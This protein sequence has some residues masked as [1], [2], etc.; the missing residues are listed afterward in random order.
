MLHRSALV[1]RLTSA[2]ASL[3]VVTA[4]AGYGKSTLARQWV[5]ADPRPVAWMTLHGD[6]DDPVILLRHVARAVSQIERMA[7][8]EAALG[9]S[10]PQIERAV[11]PA[12]EAALQEYGNPML[13]VF[14]DLHRVTNP[15]SFELMERII[16]ASPGGSTV[17]LLSRNAPPVHLARRS[18][19]G[20]VFELGQDD[21]RFTECE[22]RIVLGESLPDIDETDVQA[23]IEKTNCWPAGI[24]LAVMALKQSSNPALTLRTLWHTDKHLADFFRDELLA[25]LPVHTRDFLLDVCVL[26]L[27]AAPLCDA[28]TDR[29][30]SAEMLADLESSDN[31]FVARLGSD[32]TWFRIHPAF[33]EL[34]LAERRRA[35]ADRESVLRKRAALWLAQHGQSGAAVAQALAS[36]DDDFAAQIIYGEV[37]HA[38]ARGETAS[39][40]QWV[41]T[42]R[43]E[44]VL[45]HPLLALSYGWL[46]WGCGRWTEAGYWLEAVE[47]MRDDAAD[48][49]ESEPLSADTVSI[50]VATAALRMISGI[51]G[52]RQTAKSASVV[53]DAGPDGSPWWT[54]A[55]LIEANALYAAGELVDVVA[56]FTAAEVATRGNP[57]AHVVAL[58]NLA[59]VL[60]AEH[61]DDHGQDLVRQAETEAR[62]E[63]IAG[64]IHVGTMHCAASLAAAHRR[65]PA[66]SL[67][68]ANR[69]EQLLATQRAAPRGMAQGRLVLTQAAL[70]RGDTPAARTNLAEARALLESEPDAVELHRWASQLSERVSRSLDTTLE[71]L[72]AAELRVLELLPTHQTLNEIAD[73]LYLS[74]N[75]IKTHTVAIY[76]KLGVSGRGDAVD[77]AR[78]LAL[79][80]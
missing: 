58:S 29:T 78:A 68:A 3:V 65:D 63:G 24:Q 4:L 23:L 48:P 31:P 45:R 35:A 74:R 80:R 5:D 34:L 28:V 70:L 14:D 37:H 20:D 22:A 56:T 32:S 55:H 18:L 53:L 51:G 79:L 77:T 8:V 75:T 73:H 54:V 19:A 49:H 33:G 26:E 61:N 62:A 15:V 60:L 16:D 38:I 76:R 50:D 66:E 1:E 59:I 67:A 52:V 2:G 27:L 40:A 39:L 25:Q 36:G 11:L 72:T 21:I 42:F 6:D 30:G 41:G 9:M 46:E 47:S 10:E 12:L 57:V 64:Y 69:I 17:M 71:S 44:D 7:A 43:P 13:F